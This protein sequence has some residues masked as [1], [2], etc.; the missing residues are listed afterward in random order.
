MQPREQVLTWGCLSPFPVWLLT[1]QAQGGEVGLGAALQTGVW[2]AGREPRVEG[3]TQELGRQGGEPEDKDSG[4]WHPE[5]S[6]A[7]LKRE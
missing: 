2:R 6:R 3:G 1:C 7:D 5:P 4:W